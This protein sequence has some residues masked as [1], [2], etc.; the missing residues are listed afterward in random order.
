MWP[1]NRYTANNPSVKKM[2]FRRSGI[3]NML[4]MVSNSFI[5]A[6][7]FGCLPGLFARDHVATAAGL[8]NLV[9]RRLRKYMG[10]DVDLPRDVARPENLQPRAQLFDYAQFEQPARIE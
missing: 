10:L 9:Q 5:F 1:P 2:R 7:L 4:A 6:Y 3:R 8:L